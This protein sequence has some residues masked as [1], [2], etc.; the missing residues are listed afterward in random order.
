[1]IL[2]AVAPICIILEA[3]GWEVFGGRCIRIEERSV[4]IPG[5]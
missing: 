4:V 1:M 2:A 5:K 3:R